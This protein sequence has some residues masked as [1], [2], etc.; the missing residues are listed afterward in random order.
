MSS[1]IARARINAQKKPI[2]DI[3]RSH[4]GTWREQVKQ[5]GDMVKLSIVK[6]FMGLRDRLHVEFDVL[7]KDYEKFAESKQSTRA[8]R[9]SKF[10]SK[11]LKTP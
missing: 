6:S 11:S 2:Y 4:Y 8:N 5:R 10:S 3:N 1:I 7:Q 9:V